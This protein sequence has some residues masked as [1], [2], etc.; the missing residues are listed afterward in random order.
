MEVDDFEDITGSKLSVGD[1][2]IFSP[3]TWHAT[4]RQAKIVSFEMR[5]V[6]RWRSEE[7]LMC[8]IEY[9]TRES[10]CKSVHMKIFVSA[11]RCRESIFKVPNGH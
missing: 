5:K 2:V 7:Q 4:L 11:E 8:K 3:W 1:S 10:Y 6:W 9:D